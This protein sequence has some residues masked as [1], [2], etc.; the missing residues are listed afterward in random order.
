MATSLETTFGLPNFVGELF[1]ISPLETPFLS[2]IGG[3]TGGQKTSSTTFAIQSYTIPA[4]TQPAIVEG[5]DAPASSNVVRAQATNVVQIF[6]ETIEASYTK[7]AAVSNIS[8]ASILGNQPVQNEL[9]FQTQVKLQK[10]ARDVEFSFVNGVFANPVDNLTGRK[11]RGLINVPQ[12]NKIVKT[13]T[14]ALT[15]EFMNEL[16]FSMFNNGA[17]FSQKTVI[18]CNA[19]QADRLSTIYGVQPRDFEIGGIQVKSIY[20]T[21]G[22]LGV[23]VNRYVPTDTIVVVDLDACS[24]VLMEIPTKGFLFREQ[25][26][27]TGASDRYQIYGEIGVQHGPE[28]RHGVIEGLLV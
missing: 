21:Y 16:L 11:T 28:N 20:T 18:M 24:P 15:K 5:A 3:M 27:K 26:A 10:I 4:A 22:I 25:L 19:N 7:Q 14:P 12:T 2:A 8:G 1:N 13:L 17:V 9:D 6:Q 23:M